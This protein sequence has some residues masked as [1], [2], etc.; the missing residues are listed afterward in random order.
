MFFH[1]C[2]FF[3]Q[4]QQAEASSC[5][6]RGSVYFRRSAV[7]FG[8]GDM[9]VMRRCSLRSA[10]SL[11]TVEGRARQQDWA[12]GEVKPSHGLF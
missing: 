11:N 2:Q 10:L 5:L 3:E 1:R 7:S 12:E 6:Q 4:I 9:R 8:D